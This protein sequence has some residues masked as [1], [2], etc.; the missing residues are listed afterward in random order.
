LRTTGAILP[1]GKVTFSNKNFQI[2]YSKSGVNCGSRVLSGTIDVTLLTPGTFADP[3]AKL[4]IVYT[5]YKVLYYTNNQSIT[6]NGTSYIING[7][8]GGTLL[9]LFKTTPD[10]VIHKVR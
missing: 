7:P 1:C 6:Y 3:N 9:S 5:D 2:D 10:I 4:K 8:N